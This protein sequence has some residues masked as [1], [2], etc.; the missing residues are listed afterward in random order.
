MALEKFLGPADGE[1]YLEK[2]FYFVI[3]VCNNLIVNY[4][5]PEYGLEEKVFTE[6]L[7]FMETHLESK[8]ERKAFEKFFSEKGGLYEKIR[9]CI[10]LILYEFYNYFYKF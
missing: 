7:K 4:S 2:T 6:C 8:A 5:D 9:R 1:E 10:N 3:S